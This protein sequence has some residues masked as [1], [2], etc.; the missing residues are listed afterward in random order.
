M[1]KLIPL[2]AIKL[3]CCLV[4]C[5]FDTSWCHLGKGTI[6]SENVSIGYSI[7]KSVQHFFKE[8]LMWEGAAYCGWAQPWHPELYKKASWANQEEEASKQQKLCFSSCLL[9]PALSSF[10]DRLWC[11][12]VSQIK[13]KPFFPKLFLLIVFYHSIRYPN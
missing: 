1:T 13:I 6:N 9:V 11:R 5:Q 4:L 10:E 8:W 3:L 12:R 2:R 7:G